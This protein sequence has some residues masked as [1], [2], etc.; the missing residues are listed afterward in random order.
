MKS[1]RQAILDAALRLFI[2]RGFHDTPTSLIAKQAEVATG[3]LFY[4][5]ED[6]EALIDEIYL[7]IMHDLSEALQDGLDPRQGVE[8][9]IRRLWFNEVHWGLE[10]SREIR[11]VQQFANSPY[12]SGLTKTDAHRHL[13][14]AL[15]LFAEALEA[16]VIRGVSKEYARDY[17]VSNALMNIGYFLKRPKERSAERLEEAFRMF[18]RG[19]PKGDES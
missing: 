2:R 1:K 17:Y 12:V 18:W 19:F 10:H 14:F 13:A 11:F 8:D 5:F 6:K 9:T 3:T 7:T 4:H 16:G 15:D